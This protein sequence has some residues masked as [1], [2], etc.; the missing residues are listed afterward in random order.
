[1]RVVNTAPVEFPLT[2][3]VVPD[4]INT[5]MSREAYIG[6]DVIMGGVSQ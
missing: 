5:E 2:A 3:S 6:G 1:M 4:T